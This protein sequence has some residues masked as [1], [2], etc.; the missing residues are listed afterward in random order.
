MLLAAGPELSG[1]RAAGN[2]PGRCHL[3]LTLPGPEPAASKLGQPWGREPR[4]ARRGS[5]WYSFMLAPLG[6]SEALCLRAGCSSTLFLVVS[7]LWLS[8]ACS[9]FLS[10]LPWPSS[11]VTTSYPWTTGHARIP[12]SVEVTQQSPSENVLYP[13]HRLTHALQTNH[14]HL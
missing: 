11:S 8:V 10:R 1:C 3:V 9:D 7:P 2:S 12:I 4:Q 6:L 14:T 13:R 5:R